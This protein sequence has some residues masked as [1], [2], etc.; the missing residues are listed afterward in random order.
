MWG[1]GH[2]R[3]VNAN[4]GVGEGRR[5]DGVASKGRL[6]AYE[7]LD[8]SLVRELIRPEREGSVRL[9][10][11]EALVAPGQSTRRHLHRESEEVYYVLAGE[12]IVEIAA[13]GQRVVAGEAVLIPAGAEHR[14]ACVGAM[15]LRLLCA[16]SPPYRHEDTQLTEGQLA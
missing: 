16:C 8:G 6:E 13:K 1:V 15:P 5:E 9:S 11:A 10:L 3:Q 4:G 14:V 2:P 12:G 7:T